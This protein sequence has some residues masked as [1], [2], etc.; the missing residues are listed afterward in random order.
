MLE[1]QNTTRNDKAPVIT[2]SQAKEPEGPWVI[3]RSL[4]GEQ[5]GLF[6]RGNVGGKECNL[7]IDTGSGVTLL[8]PDIW[9]RIQYQSPQHQLV[10]EPRRIVTVTGEVAKVKGAADLHIFIGNSSACHH[11]IIADILDE[12]IL[13]ADFLTANQCIID[14]KLKILK[15]QN[16]QVPIYSCPTEGD[17]GSYR[18]I[19]DQ[20]VTIPPNSEVVISATVSGAD[21]G[22]RWGAVEGH[23]SNPTGVMVGRT[24]ID[25]EAPLCTSSNRQFEP[26]YPN[27]TRRYLCW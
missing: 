3:I 8:R 2:R 19:V 16:I 18:V 10:P 23:H 25:L 6:V 4:G 27:P 9:K 14:L 24:L 21:K 5:E 17:V 11:V 20:T 12:C 22:L 26:T 1:E 7:L 15:T 13:G